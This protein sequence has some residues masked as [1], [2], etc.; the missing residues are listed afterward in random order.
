MYF[1]SYLKNLKK[2]RLIDEKE[3]KTVTIVIDGE[4]LSYQLFEK[5]SNEQNDEV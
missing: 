4:E 5:E 1:I 3:F 2:E